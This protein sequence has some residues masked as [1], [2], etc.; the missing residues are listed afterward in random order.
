MTRHS[1]YALVPTVRRR[2][3]RRLPALFLVLLAVLAVTWSGGGTAQAQTAVKLVGT[4][5]QAATSTSFTLGSRTQAQGFMT[6]NT[7]PRYAI[8]AVEVDF[9]GTPN[10]SVSV[11]LATG[12]VLEGST[13]TEVATLSN[14]SSLGPHP[15]RFTAPANTMLTAGTEYFVVLTGGGSTASVRGTNADAEDPGAVAGWE[16]YN[17]L[18]WRDSGTWNFDVEV[19]RINIH[20]FESGLPEFS[21]ATVNGKALS[22]TFDQ[23]LNTGS[24]PAG[25]AFTVTATPP[26]GTARTIAG[27]G[28]ATISGTKIGETRTA[29]VTLASAVDAGETVTVAYTKPASN[30]LQDTGGYA[31]KDFSAKTVRNVTAASPTATA[32][33]LVGNTG[34]ANAGSQTFESDSAQAF[35][36]GSHSAGYRLTRVNLDIFVSGTPPDYTLS[37]HSDASNRPGASLGALT[38]PASLSTGSNNGFTAPGPGIHLEPDTQY[39]VV[40]DVASANTNG[41]GWRQT[42]A[43]AEDA[44]GD[45][46]WHMDAALFRTAAGTSTWSAAAR[47]RK[48]AVRGFAIPVSAPA[49]LSAVVNG[50]DLT[51]TF[52]QDLNPG[53]APAGSA[54]SASVVQSASR[55][56]T[57]IDGTSEAV[58]ISGATAS[59]T[60]GQAVRRG[61]TVVVS[62]AKPTANPLQ[63]AATGNPAVAGF[64]L[65]PVT[66]LSGSALTTSS[67][68]GGL[69]SNTGRSASGANN[70]TFA[71][72]FAQGFTTGSN[73]AGYTLT[74]VD[75]PIVHSGTPPAYSVSIRSGSETGASLGTLTNPASL[76]ADGNARFT[77]PGGGIRLAASTN[78]WVLIDVSTISSTTSVKRTN[79]NA[80]DAGGAAGWSIADH[81]RRRGNFNAGTWSDIAISYKMAIRGFVGSGIP[82]SPPTIDYVRIVSHPSLGSTYIRGDEIFVDVDFSEPVE[83][84]GAGEVRLRLNLG[85]SDN[86]LGN[87]SGTGT[88]LPTLLNGGR[89][90]RFAYTV[91]SSDT[92]ADGV[93]VKRAAMNRVV[94]EPHAG[95]KVVSA[96]TGV[97]ADLTANN[98]KEDLRTTSD[99]RHRVDG[100]K[101]ASDVGPRASSATVNGRTLTLTFSKNL[102]N[103]GIADSKFDLQVKGAGGVDGGDRN[104][105]QHPTTVEM[106]NARVLTLTLGTAARA[107]DTVTLS[108]GGTG[109]RGTDGKP[110]PRIR[111]FPVT[112]STGGA[113]GPE[114][115]SASVAVRTVR[116]VFDGPLDAGSAPAGSAFWVSATDRDGDSRAIPGTDTAT[117][118]GN[119]VTVALALAVRADEAEGVAIGYARPDANWLRG[120]G[121]GKPAVLSFRGFQ[122]E[123]VDEGT[124]PTVVGSAVSSTKVVLSFSEALDASS[125]PAPGDFFVFNHQSGMPV[126][127]SD[128][129]VEGSSVVL[130]LATA[131]ST[132][133]SVEIIYTPGTNPIRDEAGNTVATFSET[134]TAEG[135]GKPGLDTAN[136]PKVDGARVVLTYDK[137]LDP[138]SLPAP[139]AFTLHFPLHNSERQPYR[140]VVERVEVAGKT[141]VLHLEH[142]VDPCAGVNV[143]ISTGT[144]TRTKIMNPPFTVS[145]TAPSANP[146]QG[147][148]GTDAAA[149][150]HEDVANARS[151][152]LCVNGI[153][154]ARVGSVIL[155]AD[156]PLARDAAPEP[157]WFTVTASGG[158]VTVTGAAYSEDDSREIKLSL[159]RDIAPGETVTVSYTRPEGASGLRNVD[160]KQLANVVDLPVEN[161]AAPQL[162]ALTAS[163]EG[164]PAEHDG[165]SL[166][167]FEL[168]FSENFGGRLDYRAL[169]D[170][171]LQVT[172]GRVTSA[173]RVVRGRNDRWTITV[174]PTSAEDVT[175]TLPETADCGAAGAI[176]TPD[177][178]ALS[179]AVSAVVAGTN[180]DAQA[181]N[182]P[183]TGAPTI[184]GT[185]RVGETLTASTGDIADADGLGGAAFAFQW[186]SDGSEIAGA[187]EASYT[188]AESDK[189]SAVRVRVRFTDDAGHDET[190]TSTATAAVAPP[191]LTAEFHDVPA[192]HGGLGSEFRFVLRFSDNFPGR[193]DYRMLKD[194]ALSVTNARVTGAKRVTRGQNQAWTITVRPQSSE[195]VTVTLAAGS[196]R[197]EAGRELENTISAT[198]RGPVG[199]SV[200]DARVEEAEGA[201]LVFTVSLSRPA[202][203]TMTVDY[204]TYDESALAGE[205][206][207]GASGTLTFSAGESSA[208]VTV[209]VLDDSHDEGEET[210]VLSLSNPSSGALTDGDARGT[211]VD[212]GPL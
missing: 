86:T 134:R 59:L 73:S 39:W 119:V 210:L 142:P 147:L 170:E 204:E 102:A 2:P 89:T 190:L 42:N 18:A 187:T 108:Y 137:P 6:G 111:D 159:S 82:A 162:P 61:E 183:A 110:A 49:F 58:T 167:G 100:S 113:A 130:T 23:N 148:D 30:P 161:K 186:L 191:P 212:R 198:V 207:T 188:L 173:E 182:R 56:P 66:N 24:A 11:K 95:Q 132:G 85:G 46:T 36:T 194:E 93:F 120:A 155:T 62:Y 107:G 84:T 64:T 80:E 128:V 127:V 75:I 105:Q 60:L 71:V 195:D 83:V 122:V 44:G 22:V 101:T 176:C 152:E 166:F 35:T 126:T 131:A 55:G 185:A 133:N 28:T 145:Y 153:N 9:S 160:G 175:V 76:P 125:E 92:D 81:G 149:I 99:P 41:T 192:E 106:T 40:L 140:R 172:N 27:T 96:L 143:Q 136:T 13:Y 47:A 91:Q 203:G 141:L 45:S 135:G 138:A 10:S 37:I 104:V 43:T 4:L 69:V 209:P 38:K 21:S 63:G 50:T 17:G 180:N 109:L 208:T 114:P 3:H 181:A 51:V 90:L 15:L 124:V 200:A 178:R 157:A 189:G 5:D 146:L 94:L 1:P 34:Q 205:D 139:D 19:L 174:R 54:F 112:N 177:G 164:M 115:E 87:P 98:L 8:T 202:S 65:Q 171:A 154:R 118:S 201:A 144:G 197:T 68:V 169:R 165:E 116:V 129:A 163:F 26:G 57:S 193:L 151:A 97:A 156:R 179:Q 206:Y 53:S 79:L 72:D 150:A 29:H 52:D 103:S 16:V 117:V 32:G 77:A 67:A 33:A 20:G 14:P 31:V 78:Y 25:S 74:G 168:R 123:S 121:T 88:A 196:V 184:S 158:P 211:I 70:Q 199:I 7:A 12:V 48:M